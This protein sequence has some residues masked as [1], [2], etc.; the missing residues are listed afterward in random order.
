MSYSVG[1]YDE[2]GEFEVEHANTFQEALALLESA[3]VRYKFSDKSI[4]VIN[5]DNCDC[6][7][8]GL[9]REERD[10]VWEVLS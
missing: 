5:Q 7:S 1:V 4:R 10:Q 2:A 6:S 9:T 8:D 3:Y